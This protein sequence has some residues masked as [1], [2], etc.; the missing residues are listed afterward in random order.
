MC[1]SPEADFSAGT[2]V[3]AVG[4]VT[5]RRVRA[6]REL[7]I[8]SRILGTSDSESRTRFLGVILFSTLIS[9]I[10]GTKITDCSITLLRAI[11]TRMVAVFLMRAQS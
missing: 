11:P 8:G 4:V 1:F 7:V 3:A 6:P 9:L 2:A 10:T 5:L